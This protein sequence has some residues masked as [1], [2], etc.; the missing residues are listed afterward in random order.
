VVIHERLIAD[1]VGVMHGLYE[2]LHGGLG[3]R[4]AAA[5]SGAVVGS[6]IRGF[7]QRSSARCTA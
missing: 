5:A 2:W 1:P 7:R 4:S 6:T 3:R